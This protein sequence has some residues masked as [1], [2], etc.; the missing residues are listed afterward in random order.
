MLHVIYDDECGFCIRSL[1]VLRAMDIGGQLRFYG[2]SHFRRQPDS[3]GT[4]EGS[5]RFPELATADLD[6]AMFAVAPDRIVTRGFFAVRRIAREVPLLWPLL[7]LLHLPGSG[8]VGP[9]VYAWVARN[10]GRFGC[11]SEVCDLEPGRPP[12]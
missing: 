3:H 7:P 9:R 12:A 6:S 11:E 4:P 8:I 1:K 10:R 2:A 5:D